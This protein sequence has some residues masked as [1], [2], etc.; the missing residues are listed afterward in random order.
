MAT[1]KIKDG[2][3]YKDILAIRGAKGEQGSLVDGGTIHQL[4]IK[5]SSTDGDALWGDVIELHFNNGSYLRMNANMQIM[6]IVNPDGTTQ[7]VGSELWYA[8]GK[9]VGTITNGDNVQL[10]GS[11]GMHYL[12]KKAVASELAANPQLYLGVATKDSLDN[13]WAK[14]TR[15]GLVNGI[16]TSGWSF[17]S[18]VYFDPST[19]GFTTTLPSLPNAR[20]EVGMVVRQDSVAGSIL[21]LPQNLQLYTNAEI[22]ALLNGKANKST[23]ENKT[24]LASAWVGSSAPYTLDLNVSGVTA[25]SYQEWLTGLSITSAE[26]LALQSANIIDGGQTTDTL[27]FKAFGTKPTIDIPIRI[28]RRGD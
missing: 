11:Q 24:L 27:T 7:Q 26:L 4:L 1:I 21:V 5:Q 19:L 9:A 15:W 16:N 23:V 8:E 6:E 22:D 14:V 2:G 20:I 12:V 18:K 17:G 3:V 28:V 25:T 13:E 10:A